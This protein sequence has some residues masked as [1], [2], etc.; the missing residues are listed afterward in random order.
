[1]WRLTETERIDPSYSYSEEF[2]T[3]EEAQKRMK[4]LYHTFAVEA[5]PDA[6]SYGI[7]FENSAFVEYNDNNA[8]EWDIKEID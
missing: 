2:K 6:V 3:Q 8:I 4:E 5:N 1:M 7:F